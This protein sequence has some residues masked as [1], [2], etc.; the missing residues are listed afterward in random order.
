MFM[1]VCWL[2]YPFSFPLIFLLQWASVPWRQVECC[3]YKET[4]DN[5]SEWV[6][7]NCKQ[8]IKVGIFADEVSSCHNLLLHLLTFFIYPPIFHHSIIVEFAMFVVSQVI[9]NQM[10]CSS[11]FLFAFFFIKLN[12]K[13]EVAHHSRYVIVPCR[14]RCHSSVFIQMKKLIFHVQ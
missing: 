3:T 1:L 7:K 5:C 12:N 2:A 9:Q 13:H 8:A 10:N 4:D 14:C 6:K 11:T